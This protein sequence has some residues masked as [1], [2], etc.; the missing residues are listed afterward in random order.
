MSGSVLHMSATPRSSPQSS[1]TSQMPPTSEGRTLT[2]AWPP[3][4]GQENLSTTEGVMPGSTSPYQERPFTAPIKT[5]RPPVPP[6]R[7]IVSENETLNYD[8]VS[9]PQQQQQYPPSSR[10]VRNVP[11]PP[12][13]PSQG[14]INPVSSTSSIS[15]MS[16]NSS[17]SSQQWNSQSSVQGY[18]HYSHQ[19]TPQMPPGY[20]P[21]STTSDSDSNLYSQHQQWGPQDSSYMIPSRIQPPDV[22]N[23][24]PAHSPGKQEIGR[25]GQV[26]SKHAF[27]A[28]SQPD[29]PAP[30][31]EHKATFYMEQSAGPSG[32]Y[33]HHHSI[34]DVLFNDMHVCSLFYYI[35]YLVC[36]S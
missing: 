36:L 15:S 13:H 16:R 27:S 26:P 4:A 17:S 22:Q 5:E 8:N 2:R 23:Q 29:P 7:R 21:A 35:K 6:R 14:S 18:Q 3:P 19:L 24:F 1:I 28:P 30:P 31:G 11:Q 32:K 20:P 10:G 33:T 9:L 12:N 25:M 34:L